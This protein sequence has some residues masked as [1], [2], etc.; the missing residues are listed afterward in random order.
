M[1]P[2][3][4]GEMLR[5]DGKRG[6]QRKP[7]KMTEVSE[8]LSANL[9]AYRYI[10]WWLD[11]RNI[12]DAVPLAVEEIGVLEDVADRGEAAMMAFR[13]GEKHWLHMEDCEGRTVALLTKPQAA[14]SGG[15]DGNG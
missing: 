6:T 14:K 2:K 9:T 4:L 11:N 7:S 1:K 15:I 12:A 3:T 5:E 13:V 8:E 10:E